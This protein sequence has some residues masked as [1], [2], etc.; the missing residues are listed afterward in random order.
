MYDHVLVEAVGT[1]FW[2]NL[3]VTCT[4]YPVHVTM[5][6]LRSGD[7]RQSN[8]DHA[9]PCRLTAS[10]FQ[11]KVIAAGRLQNFTRMIIARSMLANNR[12]DHGLSAPG[13]YTECQSNEPPIQASTRGDRGRVVSAMVR[14]TS[15]VITTERLQTRSKE[16]CLNYRADQP[17]G[18]QISTCR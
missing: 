2:L 12:D 4:Q 7:K 18:G 6:G 3:H 9:R 13:S 14:Q 11:Q 5:P 17:P 16:S 1:V 15:V 10:T 8:L